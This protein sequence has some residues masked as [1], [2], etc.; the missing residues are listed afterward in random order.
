MKALLAIVMLVA[1][2]GIAAAKPTPTKP[3]SVTI[4]NADI[5]IDTAAEREREYF[6][7]RRPPNSGNLYCQ[8]RPI[9]FNKTPLVFS[10]RKLE[11]RRID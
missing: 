7:S 11:P 9:L 3:L 5:N 4:A 6:Q 8:W 2:A 1:W 10:C